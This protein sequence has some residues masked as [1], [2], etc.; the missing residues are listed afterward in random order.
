[1]TN[2]PIS[3]ALVGIVLS[4]SSAMVAGLLAATPAT[5]AID[6]SER[7]N[8]SAGVTDS[9]GDGVQDRPDAVSASLAAR[10]ADKKVE[11]LSARTE[12]AQLF[13]NPDGTWTEEVASGP[14]RVRDDAGKPVV[15]YIA[16]AWARVF[17]GKYFRRKYPV[18]LGE[19]ANTFTDYGRINPL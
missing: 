4:V 16:Y 11:D 19:Y 14:V 8:P 9:D 13:A 2:G 1:M 17:V 15:K 7:S 12:S 6:Q 10:L 5:A 18:W 3:R